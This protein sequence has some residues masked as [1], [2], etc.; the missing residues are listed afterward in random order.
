MHKTCSTQL[1]LMLIYSVLF[2]SFLY[3]C[4]YHKSINFACA[5]GESV[6]YCRDLERLAIAIEKGDNTIVENILKQ[7][8]NIT[9]LNDFLLSM[10]VSHLN[11]GAFSSL[12]KHGA[13]PQKNVLCYLAAC[14]N[15]DPA[16]IEAMF[17]ELIKF[18][19]VDINHCTY[20]VIEQTPLLTALHHDNTTMVS[21]L[22]HAGARISTDA[23]ILLLR[24]LR[25]PLTFR[26]IEIPK[27]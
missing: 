12:L 13:R 18:P 25:T 10:A 15:R 14:P 8:P 21:L 9:Q 2:P 4:G 19:D 27:S 17:K 22:I 20:E 6:D 23:G 1:I 3:G 5:R 7:N 11:V 16:T 26:P 24:K